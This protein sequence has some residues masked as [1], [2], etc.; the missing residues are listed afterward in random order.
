MKQPSRQL[1]YSRDEFA[2]LSISDVEVEET[3]EDTRAR[4]AKVSEQ[5]RDDFETRQ[6]T[7]QGDIRD[8]HVTAQLS[9]IMGDTVYHCVWRDITERKRAEAE[10]LRLNAE[11]AMLLRAKT[12]QLAA[13]EDELEGFA[14]SVS[15]DLRTP[16]RRIDEWSNA[17]QE[18]Y[19]ETLDGTGQQYLNTVRA[20]IQTMGE[21]VD[22]M[23]DISRVAGRELLI[24]SVDLG[25]MAES[26]RA[27]LLKRQESRDVQFV[28]PENLIV[29]GDAGLLRTLLKSLLENAW[30]AT[31]RIEKGALIELGTTEKG[32]VPVHFVRDNGMGFDMAY[33]QKLFRPFQK[34]HGVE[35]FP[36]MGVGL[37]VVLR[38]VRR[39]G[40]KVWAEGEVGKGATF[41]FTLG[42]GNSEK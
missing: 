25:A 23:L 27:A 17:L 19:G 33:A 1:G 28:I 41:Y 11:L 13:T 20:E 42:A 22:A 29:Q 9:Q 31:R 37:A 38:I 6:R 40:G 35:E 34:L 7:R 21:H 12:V 4:I 32:G 10:I 14:H 15:H 18:D 5:G 26:Q 36:G 30:K 16:I 3:S 8:I 2:R 39:H 24:D